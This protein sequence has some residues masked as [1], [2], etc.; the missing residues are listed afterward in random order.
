MG[1]RSRVLYAV[2]LAALL[3]W[4]V[5]E[6]RFAEEA[7]PR[8]DRGGVDSPASGLH[9][10]VESDPLPEAE[11]LTTAPPA[12]LRA[13]AQ[14]ASDAGSLPSHPIGRP[15]V[16]AVKPRSKGDDPEPSPSEGPVPP[17]LVLTATRAAR[18]YSRRVWRV[19]AKI[20]EA[21]KGEYPKLYICGVL[22][23]PGRRTEMYVSLP[24][25]GSYTLRAQLRDHTGRKLL[26]VASVEVAGLDAASD[27]RLIENLSGH[28]KADD[29]RASGGY[30]I[31][32]ADTGDIRAADALLHV[33]QAKGRYSPSMRS[34]AARA[35]AE[36]RHLDSVL[37]LIELFSDP[38]VELTA[39]AALRRC[40]SAPCPRSSQSMTAEELA[41]CQESWRRW[42]LEFESAFREGLH[43]QK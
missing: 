21:W 40:F 18:P 29:S 43:Q 32:I 16:D 36:M 11:G 37:P 35:L 26:A 22:R 1:T 31:A 34:T 5:E 10:S 30:V 4:A 2:L 9:E 23:L 14:V 42:F 17:R 24:G 27:G 41:E 38:V 33:A 12:D 39:N 20:S 3:G 7:A 15:A 25:A 19:D 13:N 8:G 6:C 28:I